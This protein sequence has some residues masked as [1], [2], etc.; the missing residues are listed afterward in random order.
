M[1]GSKVVDVDAGSLLGDVL[2]V[3]LGLE[4]MSE[5]VGEVRLQWKQQ[6]AERAE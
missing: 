1:F 5:P 2:S 4:I 6:T 3:I